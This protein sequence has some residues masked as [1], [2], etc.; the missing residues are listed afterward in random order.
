MSAGETPLPVIRRYY[1]A[2]RTSD[3]AAIR[4]LSL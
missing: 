4:V 1:E 2:W 3:A